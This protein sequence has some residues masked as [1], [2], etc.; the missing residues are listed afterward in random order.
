MHAEGSD[1]SPD[2]ASIRQEGYERHSRGESIDDVA[3]KVR[4]IVHTE[5]SN[6]ITNLNLDSED[7]KIPCKWYSQLNPI[8]RLNIVCI[9]Y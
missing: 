9:P 4:V 5:Y 2:D 1:I 8:A 6:K 3:V 7:H